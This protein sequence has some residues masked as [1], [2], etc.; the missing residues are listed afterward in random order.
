MP[1]CNVCL[2][3]SCMKFKNER[4]NKPNRCSHCWDCGE[5]LKTLYGKKDQGE[6]EQ[7]LLCP[8]YEKAVSK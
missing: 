4:E 3:K 1:K 6:N 8:N 7:V 2:C 5:Y